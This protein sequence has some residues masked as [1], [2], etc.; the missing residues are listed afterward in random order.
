MILHYAKK[1]NY[2]FMQLTGAA[3]LVLGVIV[4]LSYRIYR[5]ADVYLGVLYHHLRTACQ[6]TNVVEFLNMHPV[7]FAE[8]G[9]FTFMVSSFIIFSI[10][11]FFRLYIY[12]RKYINSYSSQALKRSSWKLRSVADE[13]DISKEKIT[14][15]KSDGAAVF[16]HGF[17]RPGICI[18]NSLVKLL[19]KS[20]LKAVL[21]HEK[22][23]M[24]SYEPLK[25]FIAIYFQNI[26]FILPGIG[27]LARKYLTLSELSADE[28]ACADLGG[29]SKLASAIYKITEQDERGS[30]SDVSSLAIAERVSLLSDATYIPNFKNLGKSLIACLGI[31]VVVSAIA[32]SVLSNSS[33]AYDMHSEGLCVLP[34]NKKLDL[35]DAITSGPNTC[36][37]HGN[38]QDM[39][40][41]KAE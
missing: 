5:E 40:E 33:K 13:L 41:C 4:F 34:D 39:G 27:K 18:S 14:E 23:H 36:D 17:F 22:Q 28:M 30:K 37:M 24:E 21:M 6:C 20:E 32:F 9:I 16:C 10:Y 11:R 1:T 8:V 19:D 31:F 7:I 3:F 35:I 15:F 26:F 29:K 2:A 12:T 25:L 38:M